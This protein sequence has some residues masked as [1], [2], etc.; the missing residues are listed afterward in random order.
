MKKTILILISIF[1][2]LGISAQGIRDGA[3]YG[4]NVAEFYTGSG[5]GSSFV[6][7]TNVQQGRRS[8]EFGVVYQE[9]DNRISGGNAKFKMFLG[10]NAYISRYSSS[11]GMKLK[12]YL[13]YNCIYHSSKVNT[14]DFIPAGSKKSTYPELPSTPGTIASMEHY[15]GGGLQLFVSRNIWIDASMGLGAYIGAIDHENQPNT[16]GIHVENG[17]FVLA[18]DFGL[19]YKF[20]L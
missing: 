11:K 17:G 20:G 2:F 5:H 10:R 9:Q 14:P 19:G 4:I 18:F 1:S 3:Y 6:F 13:Q 7:N 12:P 15:T 8:L 16:L